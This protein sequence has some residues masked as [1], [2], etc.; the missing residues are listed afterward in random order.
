MKKDLLTIFL[1]GLAC[2]AVLLLWPK[3]YS[4][5]LSADEVAAYQ[6]A[7]ELPDSLPAR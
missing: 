1:A 4:E 6:T 3:P 5:P 7:L 2:T